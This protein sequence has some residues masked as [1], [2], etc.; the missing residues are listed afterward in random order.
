MPH[1]T[2]PERSCLGCLAVKQR[3]KEKVTSETLLLVALNLSSAKTS[4]LTRRATFFRRDQLLHEALVLDFPPILLP[5][6]LESIPLIGANHLE[7]LAATGGLLVSLHYGPYSTLLIWR[8]AQATCGGIL[9]DL[10][11]LMRTTVT[12]QYIL[13]PAKLDA[14]QSV[15]YGHAHALR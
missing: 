12:G 8:L 2:Q 13:S 1:I 7:G 5:A 6:L 10:T 11:V 4:Y 3:R 9:N 14:W 15:G